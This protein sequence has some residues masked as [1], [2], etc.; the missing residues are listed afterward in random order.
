MC[1]TRI[2]SVLSGARYDSIARLSAM[3][4][5]ESAASKS[6]EVSDAI[7]DESGLVTVAT[8]SEPRREAAGERYG[9][10]QIELASRA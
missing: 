7:G 6:P 2:H 10:S 4:N 5:W 3:S 8:G 1:G 9:M